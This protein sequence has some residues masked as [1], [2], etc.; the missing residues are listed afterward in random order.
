MTIVVFVCN[1]DG[2]S[3]VEAAAEAGLSY[4]ASVSIVR[5]SCLSRLNGGLI[6]KAF[7]LGADRVMLVGC[8][9]ESCNFGMDS[10]A[11]EQEYE[12]VRRL[13][14]LLGL[15]EERLALYRVS[16][17]DGSGFVKRVN[18]FAAGL[19]A[20]K[21]DA[22]TPSRRRQKAPRTQTRLI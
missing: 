20:G 17:G 10:T 5:V 4:P 3:C 15:G 1:W 8:A 13:L 11:L 16:R 14:A 21:P 19:Q 18:S 2:L 22:G 7:E 12:N 9:P 6:L